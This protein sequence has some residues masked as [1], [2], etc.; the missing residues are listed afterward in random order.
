MK[1][2]HF[3]K[4]LFNINLIGVAVVLVIVG[5]GASQ[6]LGFIRRPAFSDVLLAAITSPAAFLSELQQCVSRCR[7]RE[8]QMA[9]RMREIMQPIM[10]TKKEEQEEALAKA[11]PKLTT[12]IEEA[13]YYYEEIGDG[14]NSIKTYSAAFTIVTTLKVFGQADETFIQKIIAGVKD[15]PK[16][17]PRNPK[18]FQLY[19]NYLG[20]TAGDSLEKISAFQTCYRL[21][22]ENTNCKKSYD[23]SVSTYTTPLCHGREVSKDFGLFLSHT[24]KSKKYPKSMKTTDG[25]IYL[26]SRPSLSAEDIEFINPAGG[27]AVGV[28]NLNVVL[29]QQGAQK[30]ADLTEKNLGKNLAIVVKGRV[31]A[32]PTIKDKIIG[33]SVTISDARQKAGEPNLFQQLCLKPLIRQLPENL[34]L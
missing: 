2:K 15:L 33:G 16:K 14:T 32:V 8:S 10:A 30:L 28:E 23:V 18:A 12:L 4:K 7:D 1:F 24:Q 29:T 20:L 5:V 3:S 31:L 34:K 9:L 11:V 21:D 19:G 22:T 6:Y 17:Y 27:T 25:T 13:L 26:E